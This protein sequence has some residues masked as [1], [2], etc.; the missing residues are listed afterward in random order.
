MTNIGKP[1]ITN[2]NNNS[3][4]KIT[5]RPDLSKFNINELSDDMIML[6]KK[7][8]YDMSGINN[9]IKV[10]YNEEQIIN[11]FKSYINQYIFQQKLDMDNLIYEKINDYWEIGLLYAFDNGF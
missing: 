4:T 7:R 10:Y 6:M 8:T 5:F 1:V 11:G 9:N 3:M 2:N